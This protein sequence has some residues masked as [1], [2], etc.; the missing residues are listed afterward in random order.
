M[1][2]NVIRTYT[3]GDIA[4]VVMGM[5]GRLVTYVVY[6]ETITDRDIILTCLGFEPSSNPV[7]GDERE[8]QGGQ[9]DFFKAN[10]S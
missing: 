10:S 6:C 2:Q 5:V 4:A 8:N 7:V 1:L 9:M 3:Y